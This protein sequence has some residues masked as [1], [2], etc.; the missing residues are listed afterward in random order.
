[1]DLDRHRGIDGPELLGN[2]LEGSSGADCPD[3]VAGSSVL[4]LA[5]L[6]LKTLPGFSAFVAGGPAVD[7]RGEWRVRMKEGD[8]TFSGH[9]QSVPF[10]SRSL[11]LVVV[12]RARFSSTPL[13][14]SAKAKEPFREGVVSSGTAGCGAYSSGMSGAR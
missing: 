14:F 3:R 2:Y 13:R 7:V 5:V 10:A 9:A 1:V 8:V 11:A 4:E 12:P 6:N